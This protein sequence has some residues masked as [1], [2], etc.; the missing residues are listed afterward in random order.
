M[1]ETSDVKIVASANVNEALAVVD[2]ALGSFM[3]RELVSSNE[4][5]DVLLDIRS[6]LNRIRQPEVDVTL[7]ISEVEAELEVPAQA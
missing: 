6:V 3:Q 2:R 7:D 4:V 5:T 1:T